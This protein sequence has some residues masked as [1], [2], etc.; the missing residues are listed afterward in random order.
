MSDFTWIALI[1]IVYK[2]IIQPIQTGL[3]ENA[4]NKHL[5]KTEIKN[6]HEKNA[7]EYVDYEEIDN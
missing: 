5:H 6:K 3:S 4:K 2:L 7:G 1:I